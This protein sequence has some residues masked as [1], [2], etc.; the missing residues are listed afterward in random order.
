MKSKLP[1]LF[2]AIAT[3]VALV[4]VAL[5]I[6]YQQ[7]LGVLF[8]AYNFQVFH[9]ILTANQR[10]GIVWTARSIVRLYVVLLLVTNALWLTAAW[11]L[12]SRIRKK[13]DVTA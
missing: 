8:Y 5:G 3:A 11:I 1:I 12:L 13:D 2:F 6:F 4:A 9:N 10:D 7:M